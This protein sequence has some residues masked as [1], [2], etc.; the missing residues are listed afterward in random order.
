MDQKILMNTQNGCSLQ[1]K[2]KFINSDMISEY[3]KIHFINFCN[4]FDY[5]IKSSINKF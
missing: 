2:E 5:E 1:N 3:N 4:I